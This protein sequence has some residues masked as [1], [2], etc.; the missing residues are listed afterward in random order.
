MA[1]TDWLEL[2]QLT[3]RLGR[4]DVLQDLH[5]LTDADAYG[6]LTWLRNQSREAA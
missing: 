5:S 6:V 2:C 3:E 1:A 4:S